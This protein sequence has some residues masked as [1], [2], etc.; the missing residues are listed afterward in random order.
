MSLITTC[1]AGGVLLL[2]ALIFSYIL[3]WANKAFHVEIDPRIEAIMEILPGANC[4]GCGYV[5]CGEY[6]E[7]IV[8]QEAPVNAC[9]PGGADTAGSIAEIMGVEIDET[10]PNRAV[11]HC[12]ATAEN[13]FGRGEY[14]GEK[15]CAAAS[16]IAG[17][18]ACAYGCLGLGDCV[19]ACDYD[20]VRIDHG[21]ATINYEN[22]V[23]CGACVRAC[24][25]GIITMKPFPAERIYVVTCSN[26]DSGKEVKEVCS[27]GCIAC[28]ACTKKSELFTMDGNLAV[29]DYD[30]YDPNDTEGLEAAAEKCPSDCITLTG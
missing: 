17:V 1:L 15:K 8:Y 26:R 14:L 3:C 22:C 27:V 10:A 9:A 2:L 20:A 21:L 30:R 19:E 25:R 12:G 29:L 4:G 28:K 7:S 16:G 23:G 6:A 13:R 24:P 11:V 18:Q 5:G